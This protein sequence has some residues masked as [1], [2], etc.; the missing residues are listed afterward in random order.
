M[1]ERKAGQRNEWAIAGHRGL[2]VRVAADEPVQVPR[3][4]LMGIPDERLEVRD[5]VVLDPP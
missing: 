3:F 1:R 4:E 5:A 2:S